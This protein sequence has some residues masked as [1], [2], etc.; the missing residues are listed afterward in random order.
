[1]FCGLDEP[2][3]HSVASAWEGVVK[4]G[5]PR[6]YRELLKNKGLQGEPHFVVLLTFYWGLKFLSELKKIGLL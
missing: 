2:N 3:F 4:K 1:M 6:E 5:A